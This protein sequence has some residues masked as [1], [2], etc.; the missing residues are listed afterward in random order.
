M[1][2]KW[3]SVEAFDGGDYIGMGCT[4]LLFWQKQIS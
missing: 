3:T 2:V 1:R 4:T